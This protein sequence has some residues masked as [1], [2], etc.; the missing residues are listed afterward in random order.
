M[1]WQIIITR[2]YVYHY[3]IHIYFRDARV[4]YYGPLDGDF[5]Y[6]RTENGNTFMHKLWWT[7]TV[8]NLGTNVV[9]LSAHSIN[10]YD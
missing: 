6:N 3:G 2:Q 1:F 4:T 8:A 10:N 9:C 5:F 7:L